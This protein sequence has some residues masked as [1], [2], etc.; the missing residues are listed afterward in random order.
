MFTKAKKKIL[1]KKEDIVKRLKIQ[2]SQVNLLRCLDFSK[3]K[4]KERKKGR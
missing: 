2:R 4:K 1:G 3:R